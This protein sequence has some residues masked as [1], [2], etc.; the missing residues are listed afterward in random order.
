MT[1]LLTMHARLLFT[2]LLVF[3]GLLLWALALRFRNTPV[4]QWYGALLTIGSLLV[5]A[6]FIIGALLMLNGARPARPMMHIVYGVI[7]LVTPSATAAYLR[8]RTGR[9]TSLIYAFMCLFLCAIAL[10]GLATGR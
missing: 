7:A 2:I 6:E 8:G 3:G 9:N 10:R 4:G 5:L 1:F